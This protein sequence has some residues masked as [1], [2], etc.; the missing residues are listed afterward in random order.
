MIETLQPN[1]VKP[2][3]ESI[4]HTWNLESLDIYLLRIIDELEKAF[5]Q[6]LALI[7]KALQQR[8]ESQQEAFQQKWQTIEKSTALAFTAHDTVMHTT[9]VS[10]EKHVEQKFIA[11]EKL[12][13]QKFA[14][15]AIAITK[16]ESA[17]EKRFDSVNEFRLTLTDQAS[18]FV[19][20]NEYDRSITNLS[21]KIM[22]MSA[23]LSDKFDSNKI[24]LTKRID[25]LRSY[26]DTATGK[27]EG[28]SAATGI[29]MTVIGLTSGLLGFFIHR[30]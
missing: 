22:N 1:I 28:L 29:L 9:F 8:W 5:N 17:S 26:K 12:M 16:A 4:S 20:R 13:E 15:S 23:L 10:F 6:R 25:D 21:D 18:T 24:D 3:P 2:I 27:S 14:S 30:V 19:A 11:L 7:E